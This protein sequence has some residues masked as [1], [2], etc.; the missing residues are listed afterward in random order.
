MRWQ[1]PVR[2]YGRK[3]RGSSYFYDS[4][5]V[6]GW[7]YEKGAV[8]LLDRSRHGQR[9]FLGLFRQEGAGA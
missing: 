6:A 7:D 9:G 4:A 3:K 1:N 2:A 8:I 5:D